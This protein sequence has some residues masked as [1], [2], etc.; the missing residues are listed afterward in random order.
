MFCQ[1][2]GRQL[3]D[4]AKFCGGCGA[5][6]S[7]DPQAPQPNVN[8]QAQGQFN[9]SVQG[10]P[11]VQA[12]QKPSVPPSETMKKE[13]ARLQS[14]LDNSNVK[15]IQGWSVW[16]VCGMIS[17]ALMILCL[18][19]PVASYSSTWTAT[20]YISIISI[21]TSSYVSAP[22]A[23]FIA[24]LIPP[25]FGAYDVLM[26]KENSTRNVRLI[27]L[28]VISIILSSSISGVAGI[29]GLF[30]SANLF[31]GFYLNIIA[32]LIMIAVG[33]IGIYEEKKGKIAG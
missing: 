17:V 10:Q 24:Y 21:L 9:S 30:L 25:V 4:D 29:A 11:Q 6:L 14:K 7:E 1:N 15:L 5:N 23:I 26:T 20:R 3:P 22:F 32:A 18:F 33:I 19:I 16:D 12:Q 13:V 28:G 8:A 31:I 2:C 27:A